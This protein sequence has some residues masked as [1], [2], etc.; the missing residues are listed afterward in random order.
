MEGAR[1]P[2]FALHLHHGGNAAPEVFSAP[3]APLVA[4]LSHRRGRCDRVDRD[5]LAQLMGD[6]GDGLVAIYRDPWPRRHCPVSPSLREEVQGGCHGPRAESIRRLAL[7]CRGLCR[8]RDRRRVHRGRVPG[9]AHSPRPG[10]ACLTCPRPH[11]SAHLAV[12]LDDS[13]ILAACLRETSGWHSSCCDYLPRAADSAA[14]IQAEAEARAR[15]ASMAARREHH[16]DRDAHHHRQPKRQ[17]LRG[18]HSRGAIRAMDLRQIRTGPE[19]FGLLSYDPAFMN[20]ASTIS[21]ITEIDG[22]RGILRYRGYPIE[23][24]AERSHYLET[25][26]LLVHGE[27]PT[28]DELDTWV[29]E[30]THHTWVHENV[31][32][33]MDGFHHDAH[34]MGMLVST[35]AALSTFYP[36]AKDARGS[37]NAAPPDGPTHRQDADPRRLRLP[38][39]PGDALRLPRQCAELHGQLPQH[40]LQD[41]RGDATSPTPCSSAPSR[42]CSSSTPTTSRTARPMRC[43]ASARR[44]WTPTPRWRAA[45]P[46]CTGPSTAVPTRR[47]F[48]CSA[49]SGPPRGSRSS[50]VTSRGARRSSWA[51]VTACTR[52]TTRAPRSSSAWPTRSSR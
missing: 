48:A 29:Y 28:V 15:A 39:Q 40:A 50:S 4:E 3:A 51:S 6:V 25:A 49:R 11:R 43:A 18:P 32:K 34:P 42:C 8:H 17:D 22:D 26:Y 35:V 44:R 2:A 16:A 13:R 7:R 37:V 24:L 10:A 33:F 1:G 19:D 30:I 14:G 52:I 31:K 9:E 47:C 46:P 38:P 36:E 20:T 41:H 21:R 27:L 5:D 45:W 23:D 12:R